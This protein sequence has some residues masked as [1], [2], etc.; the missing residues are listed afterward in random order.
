MP[1]FEY[2]NDRIYIHTKHG[3][4]RIDLLAVMLD[5]ILLLGAT[6]T[7]FFG[8]ALIGIWR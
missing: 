3:T 6:F 2:R 8:L 7:I 4:L 5:I 1:N